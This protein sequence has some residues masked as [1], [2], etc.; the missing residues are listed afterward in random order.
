VPEELVWEESDMPECPMEQEHTPGAPKEMNV[1]FLWAQDLR[2]RGYK[3]YKC[4][5]CDKYVIWE[6][7]DV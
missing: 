4:S 5:G 2:D 6:L 3:Q 7:D 1:W